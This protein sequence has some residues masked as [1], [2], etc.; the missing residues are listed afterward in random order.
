MK[1]K[2]IK[3]LDL[4]VEY[5]TYVFIFYIP[6][7][8]A[9]VSIFS[10][11]A[12]VL[13][14]IKQLLCPNFSSIKSNKTFFLLFLIFFICMA[15]SLINSGPLIAKSLNALF[16]KWGRFVLILWMILDTFQNPG[17]RVKAAGVFLFSATLVGLS[18]FSQKFF[19]L[20]FL[21]HKPLDFEG[22]ITG[23]F[24]SRNDLAS[25][26]TCVI[27][28]VLCFCLWKGKQKFLKIGL[29]LIPIMLIISSLWTTCRGGWIG[30]SVGLIWVALLINY[31]R[32][33]KKI[34]WSLFS[35]GY[36]LCVP[37]IAIALFFLKNDPQRIILYHSAWAMIVEHPF[38]GKGLGTFM[39]YSTQYAHNGWACYAHNCFLQIWAESGIFSLLSFLLL[40]GY[41][42]YRTLKVVSKMPASLN[43]N[44]LIGLSAGFLGL[45]VHCFFDTQLYSFQASFLFW[46]VMGLTVASQSFL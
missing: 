2:L 17:R 25:Y 24:P 11:I 14:F 1:L 3:F 18:V 16:M 30:L 26:L 21:R 7:S 32:L 38:L 40:N 13:F 22:I 28:I 4:G 42:F 19:G 46:T 20:E 41:V 31:G 34:F 10:I 39:D 12:L 36:I 37:L 15:V 45:F 6:I 23:P 5:S 8:I 44:I 35:V 33:P 29:F 9:F 27:P 43:L